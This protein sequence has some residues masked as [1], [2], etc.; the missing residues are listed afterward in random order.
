[1]AS[2]AVFVS[3]GPL[4]V[5]LLSPFVLH[6]KVG[7]IAIFG[8]ILSLT[9]GILIGLSDLCSLHQTPACI[10]FK[11]FLAARAMWGNLLALFGAWAITGYLII[12]RKIRSKMSL[13]PY[14]FLV[15]SMGAIFLLIYTFVSGIS[16]IGYESKAYLWV[17]SLAIV[18]QLIGHSIFNWALKY[19]SATFVAGS[20]LGEPVGSAI[21]AILFLGEIPSQAVLFGGILILVGILLVSN[22]QHKSWE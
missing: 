10:N 3:T 11:G 4:W 18:P 2:S 1:V 15:Y 16:L 8:L 12:G 13:V 9:G 5:A 20:T 21:L 6:E 7:W 14:I 22:Q 17:L 19:M